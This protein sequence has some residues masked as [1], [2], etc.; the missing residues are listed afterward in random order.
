VTAA[1]GT[2]IQ[3]VAMIGGEDDDAA[4]RRV[5]AAAGTASGCALVVLTLLF[6]FAATPG[7]VRWGGNRVRRMTVGTVFR[8]VT[9]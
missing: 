7:L 6:G 5:G 1:F 9:G 4:M 8:I 3:N 2:E